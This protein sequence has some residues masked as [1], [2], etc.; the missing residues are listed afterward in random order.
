MQD[1]HH[2]I[3]LTNHIQ[4]RD[5]ITDHPLTI[6]MAQ[7][8]LVFAVYRCIEHEGIFGVKARKN[9]SVWAR[10]ARR[11]LF[12]W[13]KM[14][15]FGAKPRSSF[16]EIMIVFNRLIVIP[17]F[18]VCLVAC[19]PAKKTARSQ[20]RLMDTIT[21][22]ARNNPMDIYRATSPKVWEILH[23]DVKLRF[24]LRKRKP[25]EP[26]RSRFN[27]LPGAPD[28]LVLDAKGMTIGKV[29]L[30]DASGGMRPLP[31]SYDDKQ[32]KFPFGTWSLGACRCRAAQSILIEY[33]A[34][35]YASEVGGS[36]AI[37]EE[38]GLYFINTDHT[39]PNK[40][41]QI[42]TQGETESNSHWLPTIDKPNS[43]RR[44]I[45]PWSCRIRC[46]L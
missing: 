19:H 26:P 1:A 5:G 37:K 14:Q 32:L 38:R 21:V 41:V 15:T 20:Y 18:F 35:P 10:N 45:F 22:S 2:A 30:K 39:I 27:P 13:F 29:E 42:W 7:A 6:F 16:L 31:F 44:S 12:G 11:G 33:K 24:D 46:R 17:L 43:E 36:A 3:G 34:M 40:P 8:K 9:R 23:T 25:T 28:T 4:R